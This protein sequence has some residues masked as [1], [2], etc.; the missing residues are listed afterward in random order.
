[1]AEIQTIA[2]KASF[3]ASSQVLSQFFLHA[4][5]QA[6]PQD[7][8][9]PLSKH[10][11]QGVPADG[12]QDLSPDFSQA[13]S[14]ATPQIKPADVYQD[15]SHTAS[16]ALPQA[17]TREFS[18]TLSQTSLAKVSYH[19]ISY[20]PP[21]NSSKSSLEA[22]EEIRKDYL[23]QCLMFARKA[24]LNDPKWRKGLYWARRTW[25]ALKMDAEMEER[26][27]RKTMEGVQ[28]EVMAGFC[29]I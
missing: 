1:M 8:S 19:F 24:F 5:S 13:A 3:Q 16:Q 15:L 28:E 9:Q 27:L 20:T 22:Q 18:Q 17:S 29:V 11:P 25:Q 12:C 10:Q 14:E 23:R 4:S 2:A 21:E 6:Q 26:N 7:L